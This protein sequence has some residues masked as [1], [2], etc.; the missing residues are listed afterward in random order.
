MPMQLK[1]TGLEELRQRFAG[2]RQEVRSEISRQ[3]VH[4]AAQVIQAAIVTHAPVLDSKTA[5]STA[6]QPGALKA[7]IEIQ[8]RQDR[9]GF[10][11][12]VIGP[13]DELSHVAYWVEFG[14]FLVKGGYLSMKRGRLGGSGRRVGWVEHHPFIRPAA[15]ESANAAVERYAATMATWLKG[16]VR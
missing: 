13:K 1:M 7:G 16:M 8:V 10:T 9:D 11:R 6:Q 5:E 14:H 12:A 4:E 3:A 2:L 15:D